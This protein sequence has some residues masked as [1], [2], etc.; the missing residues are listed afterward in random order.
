MDSYHGKFFPK[1][2]WSLRLA[3]VMYKI[4]CAMP[5]GWTRTILVGY[6]YMTMVLVEVFASL[7]LFFENNSFS[8]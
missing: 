4:Q 1:S 7:D 5:P 2:S 8:G 3:N 6:I